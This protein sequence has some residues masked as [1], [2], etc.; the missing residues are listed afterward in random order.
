[1]TTQDDAI[2]FDCTSCMENVHGTPTSIHGHSFCDDCVEGGIVPQFHNAL[3]DETQ[4]PVRSG[5][6][7]IDISTVSR[8]LSKKFL[9]D[10]A[11]KT[12]E[13]ST[14][15]PDR[16]YCCTGTC[17]KFLGLKSRHRS[18][19]V[20]SDCG[21]RSCADCGGP[22]A[23]DK[24]HVCQKDHSSAFEGLQKGR[25]YQTCP[26]CTTNVELGSGCNHMT[27]KMCRLEFCYICGEPATANSGHWR[28]GNP[29]PKYNFVGNNPMYEQ[30]PPADRPNRLALLLHIAEGFR[31][32][33]LEGFAPAD[34][35]REVRLRNQDRQR[36][37]EVARAASQEIVRAPHNIMALSAVVVASGSLMAFIDL[38]TLHLQPDVNA[39]MQRF[40]EIDVMHDLVVDSMMQAAVLVDEQFPVL[41][42]IWDAYLTARDAVMED[43]DHTFGPGNW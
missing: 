42:E 14:P 13:H 39:R 26:E 34:A 30:P 8:F 19:K 28:V 12:Q 32:A 6:A 41:S 29:C 18:T 9:A 17:S 40:I 15:I 21:G 16:M 3:K 11:I 33:N 37:R 20:C 5:A 10:W 1:M 25:D 2:D 22:I 35:P 27:C 23:E 36:L 24:Q 38:S 7:E 43:F 31:V 4:Y